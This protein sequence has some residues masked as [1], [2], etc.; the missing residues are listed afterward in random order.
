MAAQPG[1]QLDRKSKKSV[2]AMSGKQATQLRNLASES[3]EPEAY[4]AKLS[5]EGAAE[6]IRVLQAKIAKDN[7]GKQH[8]PD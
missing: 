1:K 7:S 4:G 6:R 8:K 5:A 3:R 2:A